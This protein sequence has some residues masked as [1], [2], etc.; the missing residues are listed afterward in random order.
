MACHRE[1]GAKVRVDDGAAP[2]QVTLDDGTAAWIWPLLPTDGRGLRVGFRGL[3]DKSRWQRFMMGGDDL[4]PRMLQTLIGEVDGHHHV[5][6]V[7]VAFPEDAPERAVGV[8]RLLVVGNHPTDADIAITVVHEWQGRGVG[9]AIARDLVQ[10]RLPQVNRLVTMVS[11]EN[12]AS[13]AMLA[14]LGRVETHPAGIG[15]L[16]VTVDLPE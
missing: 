8:G 7:F 13:L 1:A 3:S 9:T 14:R 6:V 11:G 5:A 16:E 4:S 12:P 10:R 15:V 2:S